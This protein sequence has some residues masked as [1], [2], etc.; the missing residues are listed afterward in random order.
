MN[1]DGTALRGM[2]LLAGCI[3]CCEAAGILGSFA[4]APAIPGWY[5]SLAKPPFSP[6]NWVFAPV[7][8]A[9]YALMGTALYLVL[10]RGWSDPRVRKATVLFGVHLTVNILWSWL[11]FGLRSPGA[12][13]AAILVLITLIG[14]VTFCFAKL[15]RTAAILMGPYLF[16]VLFAAVLNFSIWRL[17]R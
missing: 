2:L 1:T 17:N 3:V 8:T 12:G 10:K 16:W 14:A 7:W 13:F 4:T 15:S 11:F 6:P 9:L 5:A